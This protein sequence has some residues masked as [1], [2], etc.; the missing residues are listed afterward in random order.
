MEKKKII[1]NMTWKML[2][3][4]ILF[5]FLPICIL[6]L[7]GVNYFLDGENLYFNQYERIMARQIISGHNI[8]NI[9][10]YNDRFFQKH[11]ITK[12]KDC[13][14]I[15]IFGSTRTMM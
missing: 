7:V 6:T 9:S 11:V 12:M 1:V 5:V 3:K 4:R 13:P 2:V 14:E 8:T 15:A 10:K